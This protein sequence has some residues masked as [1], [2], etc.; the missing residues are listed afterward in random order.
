[1]RVSLELESAGVTHHFVDGVGGVRLHCAEV[2]EASPD[3]PPVILLHGF[4][5]FWYAWR[6]QMPALAAAGFHAVAPDL[7]G[8][9]LS[10]KP[11][12]VS[13]YRIELLAADV[14]AV[15]RQVP[16]GRGRAHV[17][18]HDWGGVVAWHLAMHHPEVV[19]KLV[20]LNAPHPAAYLRELRR[21]GQLLRSWYAFFFQV[22]RV[23]EALIRLRNLR[24]L[25]DLFRRGPA[26]LGAF[27]EGDIDRYVEAFSQPGALTAALNY[28]RA[29]FRRGPAD[30]SRSVRTI[31]VPTL[32][33]WGERD[34]YL[35]PDLTRGL[36]R[37]VTRLRVDRLPGATHWVQHDDPETVNRLLVN[38]L[39]SEGG[40]IE[41]QDA[42]APR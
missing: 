13:D 23:P 34:R 30:V 25:R 6:R 4:P 20:I 42:K 1:L 15:V 27:S 14:A 19:E 22:P 28:Y 16:G 10:D 8:Y 21:P 35:V 11:P 3:R 37:W 33:I 17:V 24:S 36:E 31:D 7:R 40:E 41:R 29:A 39:S 5:E 26:R 32:L 9:N 12:R 18:G 2:G 38:F